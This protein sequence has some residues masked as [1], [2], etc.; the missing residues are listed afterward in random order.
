VPR[1]AGLI[2]DPRILR[3]KS[4]AEPLARSLLMVTGVRVLLRSLASTYLTADPRSLGLFRIGFAFV[5]LFDLLRRYQQLE[6]WY[7]NEGL[8]PNHTLLWRPPAEHMFSLFFAASSRLEATL[9]FGACALC[10]L[11]FLA[12]YRTGLAQLLVLVCRVSLNSRLAV[13]ENG[14]DMVL[15]LLCIL[16][17]ALPL[18][19]RF[20]VDAWL[21]SL[22]AQRASDV[23]AL[24]ATRPLAIERAPVVSVAMLG[25]ILQFAA[26]YLFNAAS[27]QGEA[28][29]SGLAVHYALHQDKFVTSIGVL[30]REHLP[31]SALQWLTWSVLAVEW[32]GFA[33]IIT[34]LL[35]DR[36]RLIA[37][38]VLPALHLAFALGL[39]LGAFSPAMMSFFPLL[40]TAAHW[41]ALAGWL[42]RRTVP[43]QIA[44]GGADRALL[45]R[46]RA[47]R[48][49][50]RFGRITW[51]NAAH[52]GLRVCGVPDGAQ[53][54]ASA[55]LR[56]L[57]WGFALA[58]FLRIPGS[59]SALARLTRAAAR[60][61]TSKAV[62]RWASAGASVPRTSDS[63]V[64]RWAAEGAV[65]VLMLAIGTELLNDNESVP[66]SLRV[67]Q[68]AWAKALVE[69][70]RLLQGWR[71][72]APDPPLTDSMI[73]VDA[74]TA[75]GERVDPYN[76]VA[77]RHRYPA[78][79]TVPVRMG[80]DQFFSMYSGRIGF[81]GY[82]AYRQAF[83]E[84]LLAYPQ[85]TGRSGDCL[86]AFEVY[87]V[88]D[89][90]PAPGS[91]SGPTPLR[92]EKFLEY[93]APSDSSCQS[94]P[95]T[96]L[97]QTR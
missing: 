34:P 62:V 49:L 28:W 43:V 3:R 87:L 53:A 90:S 63:R 77:S 65:V 18:G 55:V 57:P 11:L 41:D 50:D 13:L 39:N 46:A 32:L 92:R 67:P 93:T 19:R 10:Y 96:R 51:L 52:P 69:Y 22:R 12:G 61:I 40:L 27:K 9:G 56:A 36:A 20:S 26:I 2:A 38:I 24:N 42:Q 91:G 80:H 1:A 79:D 72:F 4:P 70:P 85:R 74:V 44:I 48:E 14:G 37:V 89:K 31:L 15:N 86:T 78:G 75:E 17:L 60:A 97:A 59:A 35:C 64:R 33:L 54:S 71:M 68:P 29:S 76:A 94:L 23:P 81:D 25:L 8:L 6:F 73:Y 82:A 21:T 88:T 30:M 7:T 45:R 58:P 66:Q 16:T 95:G 5:L 83:R 47:M 84:W